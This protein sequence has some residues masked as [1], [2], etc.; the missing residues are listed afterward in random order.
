MSAALIA[1]VSCVALTYVV[2]RFVPFHLTTELEMKLVPFTVR[3]KATPPAV[4]DE[5]LRLVVVG[6][7]LSGTLIVKVWALEV[8]PPGV[9]LKTV[10]LAV[11]AVAMSAARIDAVTWV[12]LTYVVVRFEPFHLTTELE[13]KFVPLTVNVNAEP[14]AVAEDGLRLVVVGTGLSGTLIVKV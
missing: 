1:A 11:P 9:G 6:R 2:V 14:P 7:G 8:P 10:T 5:G 4:A 3:V 13:M 12:A